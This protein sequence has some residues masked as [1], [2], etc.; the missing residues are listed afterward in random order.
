MPTAY[1][2]LGVCL[3]IELP[4]NSIT[5]Y[6]AGF[7]SVQLKK[8]RKNAFLHLENRRFQSKRMV[9]ICAGFWKT[10]CNPIFRCHS[11]TVF[12]QKW[13]EWQDSNL[14]PHGPKPRALPAAL[15]P[16]I[17]RET[18]YAAETYFEYRNC[19]QAYFLLLRY[20]TSRKRIC[21]I[22]S[23]L[24]ALFSDFLNLSNYWWIILKKYKFILAKFRILC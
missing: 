22:K 4:R 6:R 18:S 7:L 8:L 14:R 12:L 23:E 24:Y 19:K 5:V 21:Q 16:D 9:N 3:P 10:I 15:H 17:E 1:D 20:Y 11:R 2:N 13:S